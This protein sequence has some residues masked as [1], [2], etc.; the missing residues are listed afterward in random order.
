MLHGFPFY[1][2]TDDTIVIIFFAKMNSEVKDDFIE[3]NK[4][5]NL[6]ISNIL[7]LGKFVKNF[8]LFFHWHLTN[9]LN[10]AIFEIK[11]NTSQSAIFSTTIW[12]MYVHCG[13]VNKE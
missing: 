5:W 1:A 11:T 3:S 12:G 2:A 10:N 8:Y 13:I 7:E 4:I 6:D 9:E